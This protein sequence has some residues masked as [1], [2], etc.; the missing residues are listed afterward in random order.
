MK[1]PN[2]KA[3]SRACMKR[4][5]VRLPMESLMI[6]NLP[7]STAKRYIKMAVNTIQPMGSN[8]LAMP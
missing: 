5:L 3:I 6:S 4:S 7:V 1:A 2:A 8:P